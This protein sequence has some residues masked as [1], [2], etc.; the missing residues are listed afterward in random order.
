LPFQIKKKQ[1]AE[2][3]TLRQQ[4]ASAKS[5]IEVMKEGLNQGGDAQMQIAALQ[6]RAH[7]DGIEAADLTPVQ[8]Y[9]ACFALAQNLLTH[10]VISGMQK[11]T[12]V[13]VADGESLLAYLQH[14]CPAGGVFEETVAPAAPPPSPSSE[15]TRESAASTD[16]AL[17]AGPSTHK[18]AH[19]E[20][21]AEETTAV[22]Q[23]PAEQ[24]AAKRTRGRPRKADSELKHPRKNKR[25]SHQAEAQAAQA[26]EAQ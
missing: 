1:A 18:R 3:D 25:A 6:L 13:L 19:E 10:E 7:Q 4:L 20:E 23:Q 22:A 11:H 15:A 14:I 17:G 24:P 16:S 21:A 2:L 26:T 9:D 5:A 8:I 12:D